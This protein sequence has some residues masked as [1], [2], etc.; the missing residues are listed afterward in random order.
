MTKKLLI[1][2][3]LNLVTLLW[4]G[5]VLVWDCSSGR[6]ILVVAWG[7]VVFVMVRGF[8]FYGGELSL[9]R[10]VGSCPLI[11]G[12]FI[13][14]LG[15]NSEENSQEVGFL[16]VKGTKITAKKDSV[17]FWHKLFGTNFSAHKLFGTRILQ[18]CLVHCFK[19]QYPLIAAL[20]LFANSLKKRLLV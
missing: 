18:H 15:R 8:F 5:A 12:G 4:W 13:F 14:E 11:G 7:G 2:K 17:I 6:P 16:S 20:S 3:K 9:W 1:R 10:L 19:L